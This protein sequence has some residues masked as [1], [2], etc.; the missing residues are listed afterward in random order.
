MAR[1]NA[2][3]PASVGHGPDHRVG[4][5]TGGLKILFEISIFAGIDQE[6]GPPIA[7]VLQMGL[8]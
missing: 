6:Y 7:G 2:G 3:P 5:Q 4:F 1:G 8:G